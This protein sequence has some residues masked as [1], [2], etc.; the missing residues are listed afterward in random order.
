MEVSFSP[1]GKHYALRRRNSEAKSFFVIIDGKEGNEH[2]SVAEKFSWSPDSSKVVY[3]I[4]SSGRNFV[5]VNTEEFPVG[6]V[7]SL[8]RDPIVFAKVGAHDGFS[9]T[10]G[11]N[12]KHLTIVDGKK[13]AARRQ[14]AQQRP[15]R[16]KR[17]R[18]ALRDGRR[19]RRPLQNRR[20]AD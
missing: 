13:R 12:R 18:L 3:Q 9:S 10:D 11:S 2:Q 20:P 17:R 6:S 19:R 7:G 14:F 15:A 1:D 8:T 16:F 4:S 5:V